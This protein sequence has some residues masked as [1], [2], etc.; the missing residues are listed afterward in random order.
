MIPHSIKIDKKSITGIPS[1]IGVYVFKKGAEILYIGKSISL[2]ARLLSHMENARIDPK[3]AAIIN[4]S[5][6]IEYYIA[7]SEFKALLLEST[8]IQKHHPKYNRRWQDDKSY[9]YIKITIKEEFPKVYSVRR[10]NDGVSR[11]FGPFPS[12]KDVDQILKT[13][14]RFFPFCTQRQLGK[15]PCFYSKIGLC[16]PCPNSIAM[17]E[18]SEEKAKLKKQYRQN[19]RQVIH[20]L[21]GNIELV[22]KDTYRKLKELAAESKFEE[23]IRLRDKMLSFEQLIYQ[24]QFTDDITSHYNRS[25]EAIESLYKFLS[26]HMQNLRSL[27]RIEC[28]DISNFA[29]KEATASMVVFT[30][31]APDKKEYKRF[32]IKNSKLQS[33]FEMLEEIFTRRFKHEEWPKPDLVVVDGGTP[34]VLRVK[35]VLTRIDHLFPLI[36][37]AKH[38]DRIVMDLGTMLTTFKPQITNMGFSLIRALRDEAHRFARKY[39]LLL[40]SKKMMI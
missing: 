9:L 1:S 35:Q 15:R 21:E 33:D 16:H 8:L 32:R 40:R 28:Y 34:Q 17:M 3:E 4:N 11:Y 26:K 7:D 29:Q 2:K 38:P 18:N 13:I 22:L 6:T 39:H 36:G 24:K 19:I 37:I 10:E 30:D 25:G 14:R 27:H 31:G 23:A 12:Q 5:D 20:V